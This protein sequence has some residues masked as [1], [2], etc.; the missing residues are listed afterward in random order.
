MDQARP[1]VVFIFGGHPGH[2]APHQVMAGLWL[3]R[4]GYRVL[5]VAEGPAEHKSLDF[6]IGLLPTRLI[7]K[8][9]TALG[10][11]VWHARLFLHLISRRF[12]PYRHA[13][14][15]VQGHP[16]T[17]AALLALIGLPRSRVVYHSQD[18][19]EPRHH[20]V[21]ELFEGYFARRAGH[22]F[23]NEPNRARFMASYYG[24]RQVP[25]VIRTSL[26]DAWPWPR[27]DPDVRNR[28][29]HL[30]PS[31]APRTARL[32]V[33]YGPLVGKRCGGQIA[34][35]VRAMPQ[36]YILVLTGVR[37]GSPTEI[38]TFKLLKEAGIEDRTAVLPPLEYMDLQNVGAACDV[39]LLLYPDDGIGNYYQAPGRLSEYLRAGLAVVMPN[40][41][42]LELLN[43][44]FKIG[45]TCNPEDPT[46]ICAAMT[47]LTNR[48]LEE[49]IVQRER[50]IACASNDLCYEMESRKLEVLMAELLGFP[51]AEFQ[52]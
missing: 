36:D 25:S 52:C 12:G 4:L 13:L 33:H 2:G 43:L 30:L 49:L 16:A 8:S 32:V 15:Y 24:L 48:T 19:L 11:V 27:R 42:N 9:S 50:N 40:H 45:A 22:V 5:C 14:F 39:G 23:M 28:L 44:Q 1:Q 34:K 35:A 51:D 47:E 20:V 18:F 7:P 41:S 10:R 3:G 17:A 26:P 46:S 6:P 21:W 31:P 37:K 29:L 38:E